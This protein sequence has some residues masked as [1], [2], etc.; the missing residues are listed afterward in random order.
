VFSFRRPRVADCRG[1]IAD[2]VTCALPELR[3][4]IGSTWWLHFGCAFRGEQYVICT[5]RLGVVRWNCEQTV[6]ACAV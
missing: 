5:I 6:L 3:I 1:R 2:I 4:A